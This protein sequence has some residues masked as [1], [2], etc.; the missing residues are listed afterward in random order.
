MWGQRSWLLEPE[1]EVRDV[2]GASVKAGPMTRSSGGPAVPQGTRGSCRLV[3]TLGGA[4]A[5]LQAPRS[6]LATT[7]HVLP[8]GHQH[9]SEF[10][11]QLCFA[12]P[13]SEAK[14]LCWAQG[15]GGQGL[16]LL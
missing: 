3:A 10:S 5:R 8:G 16:P 15:R 9:S 1:S 14:V 11:L 6:C 4:S 12:G 7:W 13:D 2:A